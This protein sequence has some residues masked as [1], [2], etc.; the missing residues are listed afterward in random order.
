M[1]ILTKN[2][3]EKYEQVKFIHGLKGCIWQNKDLKAYATELLKEVETSANTAN[4]ITETSQS[5]L[6]N[7]FI[8]DEII[9][10]FICEEYANDNDYFIAIG[11]RKIR[12]SDYQII[13]RENSQNDNSLINP[14]SIY[15]VEL[16][17]VDKSFELH[18]LLVNNDKFGDN[19][20]RYF[21]IKG[22]NIMII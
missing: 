7:E 4:Q 1:K 16:H 15:A 17:Y 20:Y 18:L 9:G 14:T 22:S 5:R 11:N 8:L 21:T 10:D 13:E 6:P 2:W 12:I 3:V 19:Q